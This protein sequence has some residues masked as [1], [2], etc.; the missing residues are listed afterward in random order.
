MTHDLAPSRRR[1]LTAAASTAL[2]GTSTA[3]MRNAFAQPK[4]FKIGMF[5]A[6]SGPAALFGPL[7]QP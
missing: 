7:C 4:E 2:L 3:F 1:I 6:L 5:I